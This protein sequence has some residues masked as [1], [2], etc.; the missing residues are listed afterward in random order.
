MCDGV[1]C[2]CFEWGGLSVCGV[3]LIVCEWDKS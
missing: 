2:V 3:G 1:G